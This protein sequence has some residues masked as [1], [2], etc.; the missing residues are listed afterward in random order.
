MNY[1]SS[2]NHYETFWENF[3]QKLLYTFLRYV[4]ETLGG[5]MPQTRVDLLK[6][7]GV[8][9]YTASAVASIAFGAQVRL[10]WPFRDLMNQPIKM[11]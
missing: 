9:K 6:L 11:R 3:F 1:S 5:L 2:L 4:E 7:P 10:G 8:G